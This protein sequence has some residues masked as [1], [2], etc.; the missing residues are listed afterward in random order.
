[1]RKFSSL[2]EGFRFLDF[3]EVN[4]PILMWHILS[5]FEDWTLRLID[6]LIIIKRLLSW[7]SL[8]SSKI[9]NIKTFLTDGSEYSK[10]PMTEGW[11]T[12]SS[13]GKYALVFFVSENNNCDQDRKFWIP[14]DFSKVSEHKMSGRIAFLKLP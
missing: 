5:F 11:S 14:G 6:L 13:R 2:V 8:E 4:C 10:C 7:T 9:R 3:Q 1:M 12:T